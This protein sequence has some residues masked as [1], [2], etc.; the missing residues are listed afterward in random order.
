MATDAAVFAGHEE[1]IEL[2]NKAQHVLGQLREQA[3][4]S[5]TGEKQAPRFAISKGRRARR[6]RRVGDPGS[7]EGRD[8]SPS[9]N[10]PPATVVSIIRSAI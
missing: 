2:Y 7:R 1:I 5:E 4:D 3:I 8:A 10:A 9:A 6:T